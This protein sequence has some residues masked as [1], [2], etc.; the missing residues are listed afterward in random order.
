NGKPVTQEACPTKTRSFTLKVI[1][2]NDEEVIQEITIRV[3]RKPNAPSGL[4]IDVRREDG[5]ELLWVDNSGNETGFRLYDAD[6]NEALKTYSAD[7][8]SGK[9]TSL[10][11]GVTYRLY[12]VAFNKV[13][14]SSPSNIVAQET[15]NCTG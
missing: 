8:Q 10:D 14:E 7:A 1:K 15:L 11:C 12:I 9:I 6:S 2:Q 13:G 4:D 5:F 3:R